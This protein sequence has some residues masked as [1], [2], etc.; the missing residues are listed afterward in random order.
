MSFE[1]H[2]DDPEFD[3][4]PGVEY[5]EIA[6]SD[7]AGEHRHRFAQSPKGL[8]PDILEDLANLRKH[9]KKMMAAAEDSF[10]KAV[11]NGTQLAYKVTMNSIYGFCGATKGFLPC[12]PIASSTTTVGRNMIDKTKS[13]VETRYPGAEVIYGGELLLLIHSCWKKMGHPYELFTHIV[14]V[15]LRDSGQVVETL[16]WQLIC[17]GF[18]SC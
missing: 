15:F 12:L 7:A 10:E 4:L 3:N 2:V 18:G 1:T 14:V 6:W 9:A 8:L 16:S 11:W 5:F 13:L 17:R